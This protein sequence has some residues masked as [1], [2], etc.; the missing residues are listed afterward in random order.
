ML[1]HQ[2]SS[3]AKNPHYSVAVIL[4]SAFSSTPP[5]GLELTPCSYQTPWGEVVLYRVENLKNVSRTAYL[6]FRHGLPHQT[7]PH[8]INFKAYAAALKLSRCQALLVTSSVGV[9]DQKTPLDCPLLLSD[10]IMP[11]NK[12]P[13][14]EVCSI[15]DQQVEQHVQSNKASYS[16]EFIEALKPGHLVLNEGL[17]SKALSLQLKDFMGEPSFDCTREVVFAYVPGP[18]TKTA[19][20]NRYWSQLGA[21]VNSMSVGPEVILANELGIPTA[22]VV[23]GHKRS[24]GHKI[25]FFIN[26]TDHGHYLSH[27]EQAIM[28]QEMAATLQRSH[29]QLETLIVSFL[30]NVKVNPFQNYIYRF[31]KKT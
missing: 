30:E 9:L 12:L 5:N 8:Q 25:S 21:Q 1:H 28:K 22:A 20:E 6:L 19:S 4:G 15:F 2:V 10:L 31:P 26:E 27:E 18:R 24:Q 11:D 29:E 13:N 17:F 23:I 7:L 3:R 16:T 14:G